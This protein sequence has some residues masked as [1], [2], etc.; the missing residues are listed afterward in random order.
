MKK[1][2][3]LLFLPVFAV[4]Q[5]PKTTNLTSK[6]EH[7]TVFFNG[8]QIER[9][10]SGPLSIGRSEIVFK[11]LTAQL[12]ERS[13][14]VSGEGDFTL[15]SVSQR[16]DFADADAAK[17]A[18]DN[19][20]KQHDILT[21]RIK[22]E[23]NQQFVIQQEET[24]LQRNQV[25]LVGVQNSTL[26]LDDLKQMIDFQRLRFND[27]LNKRLEIEKDLKNLRE[28]LSIVDKQLKQLGNPK[29]EETHSIIVLVEAKKATTAS[30][31]ITYRVEEASW[32]PYYDL[33]AKDISSPLTFQMKAKIQQD[34][35][36]DWKNVKLTLA[37]SSPKVDNQK[38]NLQAWLLRKPEEK[39]RLRK[40][41]QS[42]EDSANLER[43][44]SVKH[45][46]GVVKDA[47][48][49]EVLI[50]A[51]VTISGTTKG[52]LTDLEGKYE[53]DI[54]STASYLSIS[55][56]GYT[57]FN[58]PIY[59]NKINVKLGGGAA[60]E[61]VVVV[62]YGTV[63]E[64]STTNSIVYDIETPYTIVANDE[65]IDVDIK[66]TIIAANYQHIVTP[67]LDPDAFLMAQITDWTQYNF[68]SAEAN[69]FFEGTYAGKTRIN[70]SQTS[71]TLTISLGRDKNVVVTRTKLKDFTKT[72]FLSDRRSDSRAYEIVVKNKRNTPLSILV[73]DQI[74]ISTDKT[75]EVEKD[76]NSAEI[77]ELTGKLTWK[78]KVAAGK[79]GKVKFNYSVKYPKDYRLIVD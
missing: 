72:K 55:Y 7:V 6:I 21:E 69:I 51:S 10:A 30:F 76:V 74:P 75:I 25:Q 71:D 58:M 78:L 36:E 60:L 2:I 66:E 35:D 59:S 43:D 44:P 38:A 15:L 12:D 17:D 65:P 14:Q 39:P 22:L 3:L 53:L 20:S 67:K 18:L 57:S 45:V 62:G 56:T 28:K 42:V 5:T 24:I 63:K 40:L 79:E 73:E 77:D 37:P 27:L 23:E 47:E 32:S 52:T 19:L 31:K 54:P 50:G 46:S 64:R 70:A 49:G 13:V 48:T 68:V 33:R 1:A 4:A 26:K 29:K 41:K 16:T 34:S 9:S 8:A 61:E 11:G